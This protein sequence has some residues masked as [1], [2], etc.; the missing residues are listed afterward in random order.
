MKLDLSS[1]SNARRYSKKPDALSVEF[2]SAGGV[3][4]T[5]E[6]D[7]TYVA[8]DALLTGPAGDRWPVGRQHF[9]AAYIAIAPTVQGQSGRYRRKS[10]VVWARQ[11]TAA[12]EV[13]L[14]ARGILRG[15]AG[16][17][18]V[19][20]APADQSIVEESIFAQTYVPVD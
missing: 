13:S 3:L 18:L 1:D 10:N 14:D 17:W 12:F 9:N 5:L 6:G 16:D 11:M 20:Y 2:A 7:V 19:Q 15:K 4:A 8:G